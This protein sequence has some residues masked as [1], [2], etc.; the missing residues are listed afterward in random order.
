MKKWKQLLSSLVAVAMLLTGAPSAFAA[1]SDT[2]FTDVAANAWYAN[3]VEYVRDNGLMSG[4]STTTFSPDGTMTRAMLATTLYREAG[5]PAVTGTDAFSD[6][7]AGAWYSDA[8]LWASQEGVVSGYGN[9]LFGTNDSVS[10]EQIAT[11]L[12]RYAGNP[13]AS[14]GQDFVD[15]ASI[16]TYASAAVDWARANGIVNGMEGNRF[17]P[18]LSATRAQVATIL[19]NYL[20]VDQNIPHPPE[21]NEQKVLV[22][23]FSAT[24]STEAVAETIAQTL[25]ADLFQLIPTDPYSDAD[26][27]YGNP[28]SRVVYEHEH[29]ESQDIELE[30]TAP[31]NW[32]EYDVVFIGYPIWWHAAAWPVNHFVTDNDFDG[33]TVIPFCTSASSPLGNSAQE[34]AHMADNGNW[35]PGQRFS[36]GVNTS[37]VESWLDELT[38]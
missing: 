27:N 7:Q 1:V 13:D 36:G 24:G 37:T 30:K 14:T 35:L 31:A 29:P 5:S 8:V 18:Q 3:A 25:D 32:E 26:L 34:L 21:S 12:W 10:R 19:Q 22:A 23:Y 28:S 2:G 11:I 9:G 38:F 4:T 15:E 16:S 6:T 33:K 20:T 17:A